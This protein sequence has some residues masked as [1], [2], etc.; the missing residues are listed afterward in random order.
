M[1]IRK[2]KWKNHPV[3]GNLEIDFT[4]GKGLTFGTI[5]FAGENGTGKTAILASLSSFLNRGPF[6]FF[7][8]IEYEIATGIYTAIEPA[9]RSNETFY[10]IKDSSGVIHSIRSDKNNSPDSIKQNKMDLRHYGCI[11][12]KARADYKTNQ[13]TSIKNGEIDTDKYDED[14]QDDFTNLKQLIIDIQNSDYKEYSVTN[15]R[16]GAKHKGWD[17]YFKTSK[18]FRFKNAFDNFFDT[19]AYEEVTATGSEK[20]IIFRK[21]NNSIPIDN[22]STGEKQIVFRGI[23]LLKNNGLLNDS[24][25]MVDEPELSMHPKW[26]TKIL[27]YYRDLFS[28]GGKQSAQ[29]FFT[30]HSEYVVKE[31]INS[32]NDILIVVLKDGNGS[33]SS[34]RV[35]KTL[36]ILPSVTSA[37]TNYVAFNMPSVDYHI[38]L[39]GRLQDKES[40]NTIKD[41]DDF[42]KSNSLYDVAIHQKTSSHGKTNYETL[43]TY[44]RN[45]IHH[46]DS[47]NT[48]TEIELERS[49]KLLI[50]LCK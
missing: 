6:K 39:Y 32:H 34:K 26:Q 11:F 20:Q 37:E 40:K 47:G 4:N 48:F 18:M 41:C 43:C 1:K 19:I 36:L 46:P 3:L 33:I 5:L 17:D 27:K 25:I 22:L 30:T 10:D 7:D 44:V 21:H 38:E 42:I 14:S 13:I 2:V 45:A 24:V 50:D 31:A 8:Y 35:E 9:K 49:I 28:V 23:Y 16:L 29:L 12:S 15:K